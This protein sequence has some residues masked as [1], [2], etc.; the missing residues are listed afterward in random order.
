MSMFKLTTL[1]DF[2]NHNKYSIYVVNYYLIYK[3]QRILE[4]WNHLKSYKIN[5]WTCWYSTFCQKLVV[6]GSNDEK[7]IK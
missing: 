5:G 1:L 2:L 4:N 7:T 6:N 3:S